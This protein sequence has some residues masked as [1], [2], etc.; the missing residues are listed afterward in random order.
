MKVSDQLQAAVALPS[1]GTHV[2]NEQEVGWRPERVWTVVKT[3]CRHKSRARNL[4]PIP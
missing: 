1:E 4:T 2:P 3:L